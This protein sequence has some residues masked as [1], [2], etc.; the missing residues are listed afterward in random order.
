M[1]D[2]ELP[3]LVKKPGGAHLRVNT[4]D[5]LDAAL[6]AGWFVSLNRVAPAAAVVADAPAPVSDAAPE[7]GDDDPAAVDDAPKPMRGRAAA[8][9]K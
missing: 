5:E 4:V 1:A 9:K 8:K 6:K 2:L 7:S 3:R